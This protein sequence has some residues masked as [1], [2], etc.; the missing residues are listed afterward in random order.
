MPM[1]SA[2]SLHNRCRSRLFTVSEDRVDM[3]AG[4]ALLQQSGPRGKIF[5][6]DE[7]ARGRKKP[8]EAEDKTPASITLRRE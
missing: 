3:C 2:A 6:G 1:L 7:A 5:D 8:Q 4:V